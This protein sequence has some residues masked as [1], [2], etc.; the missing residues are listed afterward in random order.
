MAAQEL[1]S[2]SLKAQLDW[3]GESDFEEGLAWISFSQDSKY[4]QISRKLQKKTRIYAVESFELLNTFDHPQIP[5]AI[6][7]D[8]NGQLVAAY[9]TVVD[10]FSLDKLKCIT[11]IQSPCNSAITHLFTFQS[12]LGF[13]CEDGTCLLYKYSSDGKYSLFKSLSL[14]IRSRTNWCSIACSSNNNLVYSASFPQGEIACQ[15]MENDKSNASTSVNRIFGIT[16][17]PESE[18]VAVITEGYF[19]LLLT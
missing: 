5:H 2:F 15:S 13:V 3:S 19:L 6:L 1:S 9:Q 4:V 17:V 7:F 14:N 11:T 18:Q 10:L 8:S 16:I 12:Y